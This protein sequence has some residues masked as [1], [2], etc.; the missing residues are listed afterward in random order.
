MTEA[1]T[2][3]VSDAALVALVRAYL[4]D[5]RLR[6]AD[7]R[8]RPVDFTPVDPSTGGLYRVG[9]EARDTSPAPA[10][11]V[12]WSLVVKVLQGSGPGTDIPEHWHYWKREALAYESGIPLRLPAGATA[13]RL[14]GVAPDPTNPLRLALF[15]EDIRDE[16]ES[17][18]SLAD[19]RALAEL[20]G[21]WAALPL[22]EPSSRVMGLPWLSRAHLRGMLQT[23][24]SFT[25]QLDNQGVWGLPHIAREFTASTVA[26]IQSLWRESDRMLGALDR[27]QRVL[28]HFDAHRGNV[29]RRRTTG[30]ST[31][32]V[33]I[34]WSDLGLGAVG[35]EVGHQFSSNVLSG[36]V[37][38]AQA[39][40]AAEDLIAAYTRGL[41]A[42]GVRADERAVRSGFANAAALRGFGFTLPFLLLAAAGLPDPAGAA[43]V[44]R[45]GAATCA[46]LR[47]LEAAQGGE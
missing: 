10:A 17:V 15:L 34:D 39:T 46:L 12:R 26:R 41:S 9:G 21:E 19:D 33:V 37:P 23:G 44:V 18:W 42:A 8:W 6:V 24:A 47:C 13:P 38:P 4:G 11:P 7:W 22:R 28:C 35:E 14:A 31:E 27:L 20:L 45:L 43:A 5:G 29:M 1:F 32:Y 40:D 16:S 2:P 25:R 30:G 36:A 3:P